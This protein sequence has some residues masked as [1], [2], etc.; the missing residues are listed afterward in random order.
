MTDDSTIIY[1]HIDQ[2][3]VNT[4]NIY[5]EPMDVYPR[6]R[7]WTQ[8]GKKYPLKQLHRH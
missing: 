2:S 1:E 5:E 6:T 4:P 3:N 8:K 7:A